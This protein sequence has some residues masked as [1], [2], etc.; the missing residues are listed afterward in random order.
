MLHLAS[1][2]EVKYKELQKNYQML[3]TE[4]RSMEQYITGLNDYQSHIES[5]YEQMLE[6]FQYAIE[7]SEQQNEQMASDKEDLYKNYLTAKDEEIKI[8]KEDKKKKDSE[9]ATLKKV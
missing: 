5:K 6:Q 8:L 7:T 3:E 4:W 9:L 1:E 2:Q